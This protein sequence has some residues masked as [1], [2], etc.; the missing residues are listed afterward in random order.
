MTILLLYL[1]RLLDINGNWSPWQS[2][3][4]CTK[5]C[6]TGTIGRKRTCN[7]PPPSLNGRDC[8]GSA[9]GTLPC[10]SKACPG[11]YNLSKLQ[12]FSTMSRP[13]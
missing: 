1:I 10:F 9:Y 2:I 5:T 13:R 6:G 12:F 7:N 3:G 4:Q 11:R 8:K